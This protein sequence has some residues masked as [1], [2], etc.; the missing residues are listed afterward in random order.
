[1]E[2][3]AEEFDR[4]LANIEI[5]RWKVER[6]RSAHEEVRAALRA[7]AQL[8]DW[9][10]DSI[11]IGSYARRTGI[12]PGKDVDIFAKLTNLDTNAS[13][14]EVFAEVEDALVRRFGRERV[15]RQRRSVKVDFTNADGPFA[16]DA[17]PAVRSGDIW[18]IPSRDRSIWGNALDP[19]RWIRTNPEKLGALTS[20]RNRAP[21]VNGRGAYVPTVKLVRQAREHH[22]GDQSPGG[23]YFE[24]MCYWAFAD[25][26]GGGGFAEILAATLASIVIQLEQA[27]TAPLVDPMLNAPFDPRPS[28]EEL[29]E[30]ATAFR[31]LSADAAQALVLDRCAAAV[32]WRK[33]LGE[34]DLGP[35]FPIPPGCDERGNELPAARAVPRRGPREARGFG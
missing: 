10:L 4:A 31:E 2:T 34:N 3:L 25:G 5:D 26:A 9:G 15:E 29:V 27:R 19:K 7:S 18:A 35:C 8:Q 13:P 16:A 14:R 17:V 23:L 12:R 24:I 33:V 32:R 21:T 30:C 11:L 1:M 28:N 6:S 22:R 20:E